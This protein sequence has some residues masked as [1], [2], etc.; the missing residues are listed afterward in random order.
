MY[1]SSGLRFRNP[2]FHPLPGQLRASV[3]A[4]LS[5]FSSSESLGSSAASQAR[6]VSPSL[7]VSE[8]PHLR[9]RD[10][11]PR[12]RALP[13]AS[14]LC[15]QH[16]ARAPSAASSPAGHGAR[17]PLPSRWHGRKRVA[18]LPA[19]AA[20]SAT[21][22]GSFRS[23]VRPFRVPSWPVHN[24]AASLPET[25]HLQDPRLHQALH[26]PQLSPEARENRARPG[27]SRHQEA[28]QRRAP[29]RPAAQGE[30]GP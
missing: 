24:A 4:S 6:E 11:H 28:A 17:R 13:P 10:G 14:D 7:R 26:G 2:G 1:M 18:R 5:V 29:P 20:G 19:V 8:V 21:G 22:S 9:R 12:L 23:G 16:V 30:W 27:R 3:S 25:L 15:P